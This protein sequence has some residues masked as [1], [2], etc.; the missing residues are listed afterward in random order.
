[1][2]PNCRSALAD[3]EMMRSALADQEMMLANLVL[4]SGDVSGALCDRVHG[5]LELFFTLRAAGA[6]IE[7][8]PEKDFLQLLMS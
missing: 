3:Q 1:M 6:P 7:I 2:R 8:I 5:S 4:G